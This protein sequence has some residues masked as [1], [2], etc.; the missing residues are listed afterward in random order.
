MHSASYETLAERLQWVKD[1]PTQISCIE[2]SLAQEKTSFSPLKAEFGLKSKPQ[3]HKFLPTHLTDQETH[4]LLL[5]TQTNV[6]RAPPANKV[7][8][9]AL[10]FI[11][12]DVESINNPK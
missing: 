12:G 8:N 9:P 4:Y 11:A 6:T 2:T 1:Y 7:I 5:E 10:I 3:Q